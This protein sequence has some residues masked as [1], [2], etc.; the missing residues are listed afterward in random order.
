MELH[1]NQTV[2]SR[3]KFIYNTHTLQYEKIEV[4]WKERMIKIFGLLSAFIVTSMLCYPIW[5]RMFPSAEVQSKNKEI[6]QLVVKYDAM[7]KHVEMMSSAITN[8]QQRDKGLYR[9]MFNMDPIDPSVWSAGIGG[10]DRMANLAQFNSAKTIIDAQE[11]IEMLSRQ[12]ALQSKSLDTLARMAKDKE[13]MMASIPSIKP[14][15][16][17]LLSSSLDALSGFGWRVHPIHRVRRLHK[18]M[19]FSANTGTAIQ[20][21]G[22][23]VVEKASYD[24]GYGKCVIINHG[25][26]YK[27][28]YGHMSKIEVSDGQR[29]KKGQK[30]GLIGSTGASTGPHCHYEVHVNGNVVNP[31]PY[32]L[33]GLTPS[34]YAALVSAA[35]REGRSL[36]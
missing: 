8:V 24:G 2:M 12:I 17:D 21:T 36:D 13:K 5:Q 4:T 20:A 1:Y 7:E 26:G 15:R 11:R 18:G 31:L 23:G 19:D 34:E 27:T 25:Y 32:C 22:D 9:M 30:I 14:V 35:A 29:V 33:D 3:E 16:E 6:E 28:L 10:H